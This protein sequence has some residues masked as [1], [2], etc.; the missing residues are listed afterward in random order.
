[1]HR[2][3]WLNCVQKIAAY[4]EASDNYSIELD[5]DKMRIYREQRPSTNL[6]DTGY[7]NEM[8]SS[9][10]PELFQVRKKQLCAQSNSMVYKVFDKNLTYSRSATPAVILSR[11]LVQPEMP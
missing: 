1:M 3:C 11:K 6:L 9:T 8:N 7:Y 2:G 5:Q 10:L 4:E